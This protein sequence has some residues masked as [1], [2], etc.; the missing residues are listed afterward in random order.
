MSNHY[1]YLKT[2]SIYTFLTAKGSTYNVAFITYD[3]LNDL[4]GEPIVLE[5]VFG[6][7]GKR[8]EKSDRKIGLTI[9]HIIE[10]VFKKQDNVVF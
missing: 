6:P 10:S 9:I 1:S 4:I 7:V 3:F 2:G 5:I 8:H